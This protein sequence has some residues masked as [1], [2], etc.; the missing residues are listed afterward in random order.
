[1][2]TQYPSPSYYSLEYEVSHTGYSCGKPAQLVSLFGYRTQWSSTSVQGDICPYLVGGQ[3]A[4]NTPTSGQTLYIVSTSAQDAT[5]G[6]GVDRLRVTY[7][8]ASGNQQVAIYNLNGLT[9]VSIGS[10]FTFI[11]YM[12]SYHSTTAE[13]IAAGNLTI[14]STNGVALESTT[15][16]MIRSNTNRSESAR[17]K[18]PTGK[19]VHLIDW[20]VSAVKQGATQQYEVALR[21]TLLAGN[22]LA[23]NYHFVD[24]SAITDGNAHNETLH[25]KEIPSGGLIKASV[26]PSAAGAGNIIRA[27]VDFIL[28]DN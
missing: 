6:T 12:E 23:N 4:M 26:V 16:E 13:R 14:S 25:Y 11:Q 28:M 18:V 15:F 20:H 5:G 17:Y 22:G 24:T 7:L 9:A 21:S 27:G 8:D 19:H 10:G 2:I 1:M 3:A